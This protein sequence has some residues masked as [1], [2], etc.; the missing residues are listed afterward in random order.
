MQ[1]PMHKAA[2]YGGPWVE[3]HWMRE[4]SF[5][6]VSQHFGP[7][8]PLL[9][10]WVD[11]W[12]H[13]NLKF[14]NGFIQ[15]VRSVLRRSVPYVTVSQNAAGAFG[16][17][18][19][20]VMT[21][22]PNILIFSAGGYG[23]IPIPLFKQTE[24][25]N[26]HIPVMR[27]TLDFSFMG[28]VRNRLRQRMAEIAN[29]KHY[30]SKVSRGSSW[31]QTMRDSRFQLCPRGF[32]RTSYH[33]METFQMGLIPIHVYSDIPWVPYGDLYDTIGFK[34]NISFLPTLL[35][36][37]ASL[38]GNEI[39]DMEDRIVSF[40]SYFTWEGLRKEI[41][42]FIRSGESHSLLKCQFVPH[43]A[44]DQFNQYVHDKGTTFRTDC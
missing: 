6:N 15:A 3:N 4:E 37:L 26:N 19:E 27:R 22:F 40:R 12:V 41:L 8:V 11:I 28:N 34:T 36:H 31:R 10:N 7:Y 18:S 42:S 16:R 14:P 29:S 25:L 43:N 38:S 35:E 24:Q 2:N 21:E 32:G 20:S 13:G 30:N 9:I 1:V 17:C 39:T 5:L 23:H 44:R 33:L